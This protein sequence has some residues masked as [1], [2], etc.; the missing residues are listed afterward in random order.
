MSQEVMLR[1]YRTR[2]RP[3]VEYHVWF[4]SHSYRKDIMKLEGAQIY[5]DVARVVRMWIEPP[6]EEVVDV[7]TI[8]MFKRH[9][10]NY[11]NRKGLE[12]YGPGAGSLQHSSENKQSLSNLS[13]QLIPAKPGNILVNHFCT[14]SKA[15]VSF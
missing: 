14:V 6:T 4:W 7:S 13:S 11:M 15:T 9:L 3:L 12:E 2:V 1:L 8:T 5:Q 10:D